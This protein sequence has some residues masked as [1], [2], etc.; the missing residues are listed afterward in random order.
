MEG[1]SITIIMLCLFMNPEQ[2]EAK[3]GDFLLRLTKDLNMNSFPIVKLTNDKETKALLIKQR[4][5]SGILTKIIQENKNKFHDGLIIFTEN[6]S[7]YKVY[8]MIK[9]KKK[10]LVI[11]KDYATLHYSKNYFKFNIDQEIYLY[12]E[13]SGRLFET[14]EINSK[15]ILQELGHFN[16]STADI[17][18]KPAVV[19]R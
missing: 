3:S 5:S 11:F 14:Y 16:A 2:A 9:Q 18:W 12:E 17:F 7:D 15:Q 6:I 13:N 4:S 19:Q 10:G 1:F 8:A